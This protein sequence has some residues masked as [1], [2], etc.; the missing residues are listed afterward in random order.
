MGKGRPHLLEKLI[1]E[2]EVGRSWGVSGE[3]E[4]TSLGEAHWGGGGG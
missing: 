2:V 4:T 3:G 1:G